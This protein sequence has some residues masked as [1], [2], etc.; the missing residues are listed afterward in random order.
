MPKNWGVLPSNWFDLNRIGLDWLDW[1]SGY[2]N[3]N[4]NHI[5][6]QVALVS[7]CDVFYSIG[8]KSSY[9]TTTL[10]LMLTSIIHYL[11]IWSISMQIY[12]EI[13][14][15]MDHC[16]CCKLFSSPILNWLHSC[17]QWWLLFHFIMFLFAKQLL[18][19]LCKHW[20]PDFMSLFGYH[21]TCSSLIPHALPSSSFASCWKWSFLTVFMSLSVI[22]T[23]AWNG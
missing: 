23:V 16:V 21:I 8:S 20:S 3:S 7:L 12:L 19:C 10:F 22:F 13:P 4:E 15:P 9:S 11:I 2:H 18:L 1:L 17:G 6:K 5:M 14:L